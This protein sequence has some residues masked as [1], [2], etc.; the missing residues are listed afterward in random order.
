[1]KI[2]I[3]SLNSLKSNYFEENQYQSK[4]IRHNDLIPSTFVKTPEWLAL[5]RS[6]LNPNNNG[7]K[8]FQYSIVLSLYHEQLGRNYCRISNIKEYVDNF[9]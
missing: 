7:N 2:C 8:C 3:E 4:N 5:K 1:M 6:V 9:N